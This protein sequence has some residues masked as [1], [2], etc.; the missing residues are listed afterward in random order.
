M[1]AARLNEMKALVTKKLK[2]GDRVRW[3][4]LGKVG[5]TGTVVK[6]TPKRLS[7]GSKAIVRVR[8]DTSGFEG[9]VEDRVLRRLDP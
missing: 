4:Y 5:D 3:E 9:S 2:A 7:G 6:V 8:W 1:D